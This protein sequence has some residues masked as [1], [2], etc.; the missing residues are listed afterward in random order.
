[1][2]VVSLTESER[3]AYEK[4]DLARKSYNGV[5]KGRQDEFDMLLRGA[6][7]ENSITE[8]DA[9]WLETT[10]CTSPPEVGT[11]WIASRPA[12]A[13]KKQ[14]KLLQELLEKARKNGESD[15]VYYLQDTLDNVT[16]P[17]ASHVPQL[18]RQME[19]TGLFA[20][21]LDTLESEVTENNRVLASLLVD[22]M[23][24]IT[25]SSHH[26]LDEE[27]DAVAPLTGYATEIQYSWLRKQQ[28]AFERMGVDLDEY[29]YLT[30][31]IDNAGTVERTL[32]DKFPGDPGL[33][34]EELLAL[35]EDDS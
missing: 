11:D 8:V 3:L 16:A 34:Y 20:L 10:T 1:M 5:L 29:W 21:L 24:V 31:H 18:K 26:E 17:K 27:D 7:A 13:K 32:H 9:D 2:T 14:V 33:S 30:D 23:I 22:E 4:I 19:L 28:D 6:K 12:R 25:C 15:V 35:D